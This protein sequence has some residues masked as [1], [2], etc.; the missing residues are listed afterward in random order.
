MVRGHMR[1]KKTVVAGSVALVAM[2]VE[3][4]HCQRARP[5]TLYGRPTSTSLQMIGNGPISRRSSLG[6]TF[7]ATSSILLNILNP[8]PASAILGGAAQSARIETWP[9]IENL[10]PIYELKLSIDALSAGVK[11]PSKWPFI[12]KRLEQFFKGAILSEKNFYL[13]AA[14][15]YMNE[16]KYEKNELAEYIRFD[17]EAR[18]N[19]MEAT[20][21]DL[22]MLKKSLSTGDAASVEENSKAAQSALDS[23]FALVPNTDVRSVEQLF[24]DV[25][26]ADNNFDGKMSDDELATLP[27]NERTMWKRR[28]AKFG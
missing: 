24:R 14:F 13:G 12:L 23:W 9:E 8:R 21:A 26:A 16:I 25:K 20:M 2:S 17:K 22:E 19:A 27:E 3:A 18:F 6:S 1:S 5:N 4:F 7:T 15:Q 10:E 11:D 28:V